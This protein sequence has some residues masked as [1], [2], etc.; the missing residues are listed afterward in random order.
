MT[1]QDFK[2]FGEVLDEGQARAGGA[3]PGMSATIERAMTLPIWCKG[4]E[5]LPIGSRPYGGLTSG[6]GWQKLADT[7]VA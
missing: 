2:Q 6:G 3:V 4:R 5:S 7:P 1:C